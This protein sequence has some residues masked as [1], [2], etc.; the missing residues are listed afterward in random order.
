[1]NTAIVPIIKCKTRNTADKNN[2]RPIV[3]STACSITIICL[4]EI[5]EECLDNYT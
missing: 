5:N 2:Y 3:L 4:L 1:M